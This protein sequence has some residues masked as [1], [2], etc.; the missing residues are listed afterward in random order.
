MGSQFPNARSKIIDGHSINVVSSSG[1]D[2]ITTSSVNM[3]SSL[4]KLI[5]KI[6]IAIVIKCFIEIIMNYSKLIESI[7][8]VPNCINLIL[9]CLN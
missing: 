6:N 1:S 9:L 5:L 4:K 8:F 7:V 2:V 3:D